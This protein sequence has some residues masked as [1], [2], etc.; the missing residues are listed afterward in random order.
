M[1]TPS[2]NSSGYFS[3]E[4]S[5]KD[6]TDTDGHL[7]ETGGHMTETGGHGTDT[8]GHGT[9]PGGHGTD[10]GFHVGSWD[11]VGITLRQVLKRYAI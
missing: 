7:T 9:D 5:N 10:T 11:L 6:V 8:G 2:G 3:H 4:N 1:S